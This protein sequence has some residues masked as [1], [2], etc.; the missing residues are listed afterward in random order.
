MWL[1]ANTD[2]QRASIFTKSPSEVF[3]PAAREIAMGSKH[4]IDETQK[5]PGER[6][7]LPWPQ[8]IKMNESLR[9]KIAS[10]LCRKRCG[11]WVGRYTSMA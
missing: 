5:L 8:R 2:P 10:F 4:V 7:K 11:F 6:F 3:D 1:F 9:K